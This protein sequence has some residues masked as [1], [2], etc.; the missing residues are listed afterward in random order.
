MGRAVYVVAYVVAYVV[1]SVVASVVCVMY[2]GSRP[3]VPGT[4]GKR[5][6]HPCRSHGR[7]AQ[8]SHNEEMTACLAQ[9]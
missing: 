9:T 1:M 8:P 3:R 2:S 5:T 4:G 6:S 7:M